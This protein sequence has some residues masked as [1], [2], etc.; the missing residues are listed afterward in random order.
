[1]HD[2]MHDL[3]RSVAGDVY[4]NAK[5]DL[6]KDIGKR[7]Y[8]LHA[9]IY[10]ENLSTITQA[11]GKKPLY[12]RTLILNYFSLKVDQLEFVFSELK[13]LQALDLTDNGI[14]E[15]PTSIRNLIHLRHLNLSK[16]NIE[17]LPDS[18][19]FLPNLQYLDLSFNRGLRELPKELGN[20]QSLRDLDCRCHDLPSAF[21]KSDLRLTH[22][23][24]GLSRL[25][26]LQSLRVFVAGDRIGAC[27]IIELE[28]LKLYG[29]IN[30]IFS[31]NF[32]N[33]SCGG[34]KVLKNK[35]LNELCLQFNGSERYDKEM[36][37]DLCPNKS[38]KKL[39]ICNY[40]SRQFPAWLIDSQLPNLVEVSLKNCRDCEHIPPLGN[41]QFVK[42]IDLAF[43]SGIT[44]MGAEFHGR[45]GFPSLQELILNGLYNLEEWSES[46]G[47]DE[48]FPSLQW[49]R[50]SNCPKLKCMPR[51]PKIH[52]LEIFYCSASLLSC[53]DRLTSL[54]VLRAMDIDGMSFFP[55]GCIRN[56]TSLMELRITRCRQL[57]SL[58]GDEM[59][60]LTSLTKLQIIQC[61]KLQSLPGDEMQHLKM[62]RSLTID[63]CY[64]LA[65][66]PS[67]V[68]RLNSL[69]FLRLA[70]C[71]SIILQPE[72]LVQ[73]LN[74]VHEFE[75]T[76]CGNNINLRGQLQHLHTLRELLITGEHDIYSNTQLGI[77]CCDELES[78]MTAEPSSSVLQHLHIDG[79]SNLTTLPDWLQH[80]KSLRFLSIYN[81]SRL[82]TLPR[83]LKSLHM[84][85]TLRIIDCPQ[86]KR[87][88][89]R[90]TGED[91]SIISHVSYVDV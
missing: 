11:L 15:V 21:S 65:S 81:C 77:C 13:F 57:L 64:N 74:S 80:L 9:H 26:N 79:I 30:I 33:Y 52:S 56:L 22:M 2:L 29:E 84:L 76:I 69:H 62:I 10:F 5:E 46:H 82:G 50:I 60:H 53:V 91:W 25:T 19:T 59:Q 51:L 31:E 58:P 8:H 63:R 14:G 39:S 55:S 72:E 71:P 27:S 48:L 47:V 43:M 41:L 1:M 17:V 37:D 38:L 23:P 45:R 54:S 35:N 4:W 6:A 68:G 3:A 36:L 18:I 88:C 44:Q 7:T 85:E 61:T 32:T 70:S 20:M 28:D 75:V 49:L 83:G 34:R 66:F 89:E 73:I 24:C 78:L 90:D 16:N 40:G 87:R 42:K 12:L 86:L 67:K